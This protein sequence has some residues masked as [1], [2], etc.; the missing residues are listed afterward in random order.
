MILVGVATG[1]DTISTSVM[2]HTLKLYPVPAYEYIIVQFEMHRRDLVKVF[3]VDATGA[4]VEVV[5]AKNI[6]QG[7][8]KIILPIG[9]YA[10]GHYSLVLQTSNARQMK[11]FVKE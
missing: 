10:G 2:N 4:L 6:E 1:I 7:T 5:Q 8:Y 9:H 3:I 11:R